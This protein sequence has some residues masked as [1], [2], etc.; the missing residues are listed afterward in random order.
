V[1]AVDAKLF[2]LSV[3]QEFQLH[4]FAIAIQKTNA[5]QA[6]EMAVKIYQQMLLRDNA[7]KVMMKDCLHPSLGRYAPIHPE[8]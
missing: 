7:Y 2:E 3:E 4:S 6:Q 1:V 5:E 8:G